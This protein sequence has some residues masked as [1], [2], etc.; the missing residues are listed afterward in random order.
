MIAMM[1]SALTDGRVSNPK[2]KVRTSIPK[3]RT[4]P[5]CAK[6]HEYIVLW[7]HLCL[8]LQTQFSIMVVQFYGA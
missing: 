1:E 7:Q 4:K 2:N 3:G 5:K 8:S 6:S